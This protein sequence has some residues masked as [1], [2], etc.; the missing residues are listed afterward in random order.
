MKAAWVAKLKNEKVKLKAPCKLLKFFK[1]DD[2]SGGFFFFLTFPDL[3]I[4]SKMDG[5]YG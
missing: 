5:I 3:S 2:I 1:S 4:L